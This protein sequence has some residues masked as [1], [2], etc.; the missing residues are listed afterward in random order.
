VAPP[1]T[2]ATPGITDAEFELLSRLVHE[3]AGIYLSEAKR[4]LLA[5][6]LARRLRALGLRSYMALYRLARADAAERQR[7]LEAITTHETRFFR[8]PRQFE[9]LEEVAAPRWR[10]EAAAG[11]RPRRL[12]AWSA[13]CSTGEEAYSLAMLLGSCLPPAAGWSVEVLATDL[14]ER[15]LERAR[16]GVWPLAKADDIPA[17]HLETWM[18]RGVRGREGSMAASP[19]LRRLIRFE[20]ANL[21]DERLAVAGPFDLVL[22]RNVLIYFRPDRRRLVVERLLARLAP[23]GYVLLGHAESLAEMADRVRSV[24]PMVYVPHAAPPARERR[25]R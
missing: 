7:V 14:S 23:G 9:F 21:N 19:A 13:G 8:E 22:C 2:P 15:A 6:R 24:G 3:E 17:G 25:P 18:R 11:R 16:E 10:A 1:A 12:R 20:R 5:G 4:P